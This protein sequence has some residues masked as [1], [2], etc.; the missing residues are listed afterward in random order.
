MRINPFWLPGLFA[1]Q[2]E[3]TAL[4]PNAGSGKGCGDIE[5]FPPDPNGLTSWGVRNPLSWRRG[6]RPV[7]SRG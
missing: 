3:S 5:S 6:L 7:H 2:S 4:A 1:S